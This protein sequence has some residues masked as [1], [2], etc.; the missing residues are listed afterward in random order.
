MSAATS[1]FAVPLLAPTLPPPPRLRRDLDVARSAKAGR[2]REAGRHRFCMKLRRSAVALA[3]A[4]GPPQSIARI[5][6][7]TVAVALLQPSF[8]DAQAL[9]VE[10]L[11]RVAVERAPELRA[12]RYDVAAAGGQVVQAGLRSNPVLTASQELGGTISSTAGVEWPLDLFRRP[13]RIDVAERTRDRAA[14]SVE[15]RARLIAAAVR[16]QAGRLLA[17]RRIV[18]VTNEALAAARRMRDLLDRRVT[19]GG[20]PKLEANLAAVEALRIEADA[21]LAAGEAEAA[22]I[23]LKAMAGFPADAALVITDSLEPLVRAATATDPVPAVALDARPDIRDALARI[24]LADAQAERARQEGRFDITVSGGYTRMDFGFPQ[25]GFDDRG[26]RVPIEGI[27]HSVT[28][29]ARVTLPLFHQNQGALASALAERRSA[30][31]TLEA[32]QRAARAE[33]DAAIARDRD[34]RRAVELYASTVR[35]LARQNVDVILEA[36]DLGRFPLTDL[37]AQQRRYLEVEAAYTEVLSRAYQARSAVR[38]AL[39]EIP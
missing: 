29:G 3:E 9:T 27:F 12:A 4:E 19:E 36:Y 34:A 39:G 17:A 13:A 21:G 16:E 26:V 8:A 38:R 14:L 30:E 23:E 22:D 28:L 25:Q 32:E 18:E 20:V 31:A 35:D 24:T 33:V 7:C 6:L 15:G 1:L 2:V 5:V 10:E 37:L 11:V